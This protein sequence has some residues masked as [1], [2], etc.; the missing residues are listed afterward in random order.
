MEKKWR[1][2]RGVSFDVLGV[3]RLNGGCDY[4]GRG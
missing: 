2:G 1:W 4:R 3:G